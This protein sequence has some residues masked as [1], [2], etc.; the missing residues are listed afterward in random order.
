MQVR[1]G[2]CGLALLPGRKREFL[3]TKQNQIKRNDEKEDRDRTVLGLIDAWR[4]RRY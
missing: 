1:L 2:I 3:S 4:K